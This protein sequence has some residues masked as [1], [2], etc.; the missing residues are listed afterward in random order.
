MKSAATIIIG[1]SLLLQPGCNQ[2]Q[3]ERDS[4]V[5]PAGANQA[6]N[7]PVITQSDNEV[8][9]T[10]LSD[11]L[12]NRDKTPLPDSWNELYFIN[13]PYRTSHEFWSGDPDELWKDLPE[14]LHVTAKST[15][16]EMVKRKD[17]PASFKGFGPKDKRIR[18]ETSVASEIRFKR[19]PLHEPH[20]P[21]GAWLPGYSVDKKYAV[22][23]LILPW[24]IHSATGTFF[25]VNRDGK[26]HVVERKFVYYP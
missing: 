25:L 19:D 10:V 14:S 8:L 23:R 24:S 9:D 16:M 15:Y 22:V 20:R 11:L 3:P 12:N 26:W 4:S 21:G 13:E 2:C 18:L 5:S 6:P 7:K 17:D 1:L